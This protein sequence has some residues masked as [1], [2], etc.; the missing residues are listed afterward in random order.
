MLQ[1][2]H[3]NKNSETLKVCCCSNRLWAHHCLCG[4]GRLVYILYVE[5]VPCMFVGALSPE[6]ESKKKREERK[7]RKKGRESWTVKDREFKEEEIIC[8]DI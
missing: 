3:I 1:Q 4:T 6:R 7:G 5:S 2:L 8:K